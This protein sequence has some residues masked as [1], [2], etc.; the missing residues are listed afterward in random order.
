VWCGRGD[1]CEMWTD[2]VAEGVVET[3]GGWCTG[4]VGAELAVGGGVGGGGDDSHCL[5]REGW[6]SLGGCKLVD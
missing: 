1:G 5:W 3:R 6:V 4:G 2:A